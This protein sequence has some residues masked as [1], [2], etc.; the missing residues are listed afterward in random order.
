[1]CREDSPGTEVRGRARSAPA[2]PHAC[3]VGQLPRGGDLDPCKGK[4]FLAS[5]GMPITFLTLCLY[6]PFCSV[7]VHEHT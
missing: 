6:A 5:P 2:V 7:H 4:G 3:S 1:M